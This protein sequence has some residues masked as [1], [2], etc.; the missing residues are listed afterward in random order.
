MF[1]LWAKIG[2]IVIFKL[3]FLRIILTVG[4]K[5]NTRAAI[6]KNT[7]IEVKYKLEGSHQMA[8]CREFTEHFTYNMKTLRSSQQMGYMIIMVSFK[9]YEGALWIMICVYSTEN[10]IWSKPSLLETCNGKCSKEDNSYNP[11]CCIQT[12]RGTLFPIATPF[13]VN[14]PSVPLPKYFLSVCHKIHFPDFRNDGLKIILAL[15][16]Q[17]S[18]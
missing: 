10:Y 17:I 15:L 18:K 16:W 8:T 14:S 7:V 11:G 1:S 3:W 4:G 12:G 6:K 5:S 9:K 2:Q 13:T